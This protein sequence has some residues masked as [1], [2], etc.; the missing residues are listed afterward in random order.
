MAPQHSAKTSTTTKAKASNAR[1][2]AA[3]APKKTDA[4][5]RRTRGMVPPRPP[6]VAPSPTP[7]A[8]PLE[9]GESG[10]KPSVSKAIS[11]ARSGVNDIQGLLAQQ[12]SIHPPIRAHS[13]SGKLEQ[14]QQDKGGATMPAFMSPFAATMTT[15]ASA[16]QH[17]LGRTFSTLPPL[18]AGTAVKAST[19]GIARTASTAGIASMPVVSLSAT[20]ASGSD[21]QQRSLSRPPSSLQGQA[22][23]AAAAEGHLPATAHAP[24]ASPT[25]QAPLLSS[26]R[27]SASADGAS[28]LQADAQQLAGSDPSNRLIPSLTDSRGDSYNSKTHTTPNPLQAPSPSLQLSLRDT[29]TVYDDGGGGQQAKLHA[30]LTA[31]RSGSPSHGSIAFNLSGLS[32]TNSSLFPAMAAQSAD[33]EQASKSTSHGADATPDLHQSV[34][35]RQG[36]ALSR[37]KSVTF[38]G[39]QALGPQPGSTSSSQRHASSAAHS[40]G[41]DESVCLPPGAAQ[42]Q[43]AHAEGP[44]SNDASSRSSRALV[45]LSSSLSAAVSETMQDRM[46]AGGLMHKL[47]GNIQVDRC[48]WPRHTVKD[49]TLVDRCPLPRHAVKDDTNLDRC[50]WPRH[51][52]KSTGRNVQDEIHADSNA[53]QGKRSM[54]A[55]LARHQSSLNQISKR[56]DFAAA[57]QAVRSSW[58]ADEIGQVET[59]SSLTLKQSDDVPDC[60][61]AEGEPSSFDADWQSITQRR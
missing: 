61:A 48:P 17:T 5:R 59:R 7:T 52:V 10:Q 4:P 25:G 13:P 16:Q 28:P 46:L 41:Q 34:H 26:Q 39:A 18:T 24:R 33:A 14:L 42:L 23:R 21:L 55:K 45:R 50:L 15:G 31:Q 58:R 12:P 3:P 32:A 30:A 8:G 49:E 44:A 56:P 51:T 19:A 60:S 29:A 40:E 43:K 53:A 27:G 1:Q 47:P 6:S 2:P 54:P 22:P 36:S 35:S 38:G 9:D 20:A 57:M 37:R 11:M